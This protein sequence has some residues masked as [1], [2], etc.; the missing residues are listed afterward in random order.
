VIVKLAT[1]LM[2][3][4]QRYNVLNLY[5]NRT[6]GIKGI[7]VPLSITYTYISSEFDTNIAD[8]AFYG[9]VIASESIPYIPWFRN[10]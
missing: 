10:E 8:T 4:Q 7:K 3:M 9:Y 2:V 5:Q 1:P 6:H